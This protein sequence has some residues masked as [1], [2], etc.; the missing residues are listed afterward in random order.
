MKNLEFGRTLLLLKE[1]LDQVESKETD[2]N[3]ETKLVVKGYE[4]IHR[5][6]KAANDYI[7]YQVNYMNEQLS[8]KGKVPPPFDTWEDG[9][10]YD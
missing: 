2:G 3:V 5:N 1:I 7:E 10:Q 9:K 4:I 6:E 8:K